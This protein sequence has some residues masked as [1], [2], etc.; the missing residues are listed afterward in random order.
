MFFLK[1]GE[2]Y[3]ITLKSPILKG[4]T[5]LKETKN[6][7]IIEKTSFFKCAKGK[8]YYHKSCLSKKNIIGIK[9]L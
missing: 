9:N 5:V 6:S 7:Y 3:D 1:I 8:P 4:W 2:K